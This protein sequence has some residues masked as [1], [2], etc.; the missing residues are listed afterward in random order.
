[1]VE[2]FLIPQVKAGGLVDD[3]IIKKSVSWFSGGTV[4]WGAVIGT[5][6]NLIVFAAGVMGMVFLLRG[7]IR[8]ITASGDQGKMAEGRRMMT[9]AVV[10]LI[11]SA[12]TFSIL[13]TIIM[14]FNITEIDP[15]I[16]G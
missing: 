5:V 15:G 10:G 13:Q 11:D 14:V 16:I 7:A 9:Y 1:M 12:A 2:N 4:Q 3:T 6:T 8:V